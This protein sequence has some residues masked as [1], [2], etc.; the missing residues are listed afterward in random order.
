[1][2]SSPRSYP[3]AGCGRFNFARPNA[4]CYWCRR[5]PASVSYDQF[6]GDVTFDVACEVVRAE[7][8]IAYEQGAYDFRSTRRAAL[9][10]MRRDK[11]SAFRA[12]LRTGPA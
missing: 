2:T 1:M 7:K 8:A 4:R 9:D 10:M 3:C 12:F 5:A 11:L 6:R